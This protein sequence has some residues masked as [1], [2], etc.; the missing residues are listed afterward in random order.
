MDFAQ[1]QK[2][3]SKLSDQEKKVLYITALIV[4]VALVDRLFLGPVFER[5]KTVDDDISQ[6]KSSV[7]RDIRFLS[8]KDRILSESQAYSKYFTNKVQDD[9]VV[10]ADFLSVVER[11]ATRSNVNLVKSNPSESKKKKDFVEYYANLDCSGKLKDVISFM[12]QI[13]SSDELLKIVKFN[14]SPKKGA[15]DEVTAS[16]TVEKFVATL[17]EPSA[18]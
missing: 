5:L 1:I 13:N 11:L 4:L 12:H 16:M 7:S 17:S 9:D 18:R 8:Y 10:N 2:F 3:I 14:M 15:E 6:Q